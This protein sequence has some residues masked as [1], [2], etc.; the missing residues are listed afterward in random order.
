[1]SGP[2]PRA[3]SQR[4]VHRAAATTDASTV[5]PW[6]LRVLRQR[7]RSDPW[8][9]IPHDDVVD[10]D[11]PRRRAARAG[12]R[13]RL[14]LPARPLRSQPPGRAAPR[15]RQR[16][17]P[18]AALIAAALLSAACG[19]PPEAQ[20]A[21]PANG[22]APVVA[23]P[24]D[25]QAAAVELARAQRLLRA[26]DLPAARAAFEAATRA[27]PG[28]ARGF[29]GLGRTL[30]L[31]GPGMSYSRARE[32]FA[33]ALELDPALAEAH[34]GLGLAAY[35]LVEYEVAER[36]FA[37]FLAAA[38]DDVPREM[39]GEAHHFLGVLA[40]ERGAL[41]EALARF[42]QAAA[43]H[44]RFADTP[45]ERG[46]T[47]EAAGRLEE[48]VAAFEAALAIERNHLPCWFRLARV[49]R[50]LGRDAAA[51][52]AERIH[53]ALNGLFDDTTGRSAQDPAKRAA[54]WGEIAALDPENRGARFEHARA[55][56]ELGR[57]A[58]AR[59]ALDDLVAAQPD[60]GE[61]HQLGA[62]L[63]LRDGDRAGALARVQALRR[64]LPEL[65]R[66]QIAPALRSL[67][68]TP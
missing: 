49:C 58:E 60:F 51:A 33:R 17:A 64:A 67:W 61:A 8:V 32:A 42:E 11:A 19:D 6:L 41:D 46:L 13:L 34:W 59:L 56:V 26:G 21:P 66:E 24:R 36:E 65:R 14:P 52:R 28:D 40:R 5:V 25:P 68:E 18:H 15:F 55:L 23:A 38:G 22:G 4:E 47:L 30:V 54:C 29:Q 50:A 2:P 20:L 9:E 7:L 10:P 37:R 27:D 62:E 1:M 44:P 3:E 39:L 63:A 43:L 45:Y 53:R 57:S 12:D 48:A 16:H 31:K 35:G